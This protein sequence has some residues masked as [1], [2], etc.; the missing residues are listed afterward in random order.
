MTG[1]LTRWRAARELR[2]RAESYMRTLRQEP[3]AAD[4]D[5]LARHGTRGDADRARW[6]LRY[7]RMALGRLAA[8][9]DAMDDSTAAAVAR[10]IGDFFARDPD[11][12]GDRR[13]VAERQ[14][15]DRLAAY[16]DA[17]EARSTGG[18]SPTRI[19][20]ARVL[21]GFAAGANAGDGRTRPAEPLPAETHVAGIVGAYLEEAN[22]ALRRD[23]GAATL[24]DDIPPS[25]AG[26]QG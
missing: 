5:W 6:E 19:R 13:A 8:Q 15:N 20:L 16:A 2:R 14:F 4:V 17:I 26:G 9:R 18:S 10:R 23:F 12:A 21:L 7:A 22:E 24:P 3:N 11:V 25:A 1:L